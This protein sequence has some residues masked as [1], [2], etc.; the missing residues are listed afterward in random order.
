MMNQD[1][2]FWLDF[3]SRPTIVLTPNEIYHA[4]DAALIDRIK[5][6]RRIEKKPPKFSPRQL[7]DYISMWANTAPHGGIIIVGI[8]KDTHFAGIA[9]LGEQAINEREK[10]GANYCPD[11]RIETKRLEIRNARQ[12]LDHLLVIRVHYK[13][14]AVVKTVKGEAFI[15]RGDSKYLLS[16]VEVTQ[17][18]MDKGELSLEQQV[19]PLSYPE[20]FDTTAI[21]PFCQN[22]IAARH[23]EQKSDLDVLEL[24]HLGRRRAGGFTPNVACA[25]LFAKDPRLMIPGCR[26]RFFRFEGDNEG[27]G[28]RFSPVR[29]R[30]I[31]GTIPVIIEESARELRTQL[32]MFSALGKDGKFYTTPE[33]PDFAWY[34][35]IVNACAHRSYGN[36][37]KN[38][39]IFVKMFDDRLV[40]ESPGPFPPFVTPEN[41]YE[42]HHPRNPYLMEAMFYLNFV[43]CAHEGTRRIRDLMKKNKLPDPE[44]RQEEVGHAVVRVTLRNNIK[45]RKMWIDAD[46][47]KLIGEAIARD[48]T[49]EEKRVLNFVAEHNEISV[50]QVQ[51]L[52][53][54]SWPASRKLIAGLEEKGLMLRVRK[55]KGDKRDPG[56]RYVLRARSNGS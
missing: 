20:D 1:G 24:L 36:G 2:Q 49:E 32:R 7:G 40:V 26:I 37:M 16:P 43:K 46:I 50:S 38:M 17:L 19:A 21:H 8:E 56:V 9:G 11:A 25:L 3:E 51:R 53:Q 23:W 5:E 34:E 4:D 22:V 45:Q 10:A 52:T 42:T 27:S 29:D 28:E 15:R 54:R 30:F 47:S 6:D 39:N 55:T 31:D 48:L 12:Q 44:F 18:Q 13:Q 14:D 41:I 35:A 33:Y